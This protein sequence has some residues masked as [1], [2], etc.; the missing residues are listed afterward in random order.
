M[1]CCR[2]PWYRARELQQDTTEEARWRRVPEVLDVIG[3][4]ARRAL[5][6][7]LWFIFSRAEC[8]EAAMRVGAEPR[9]RLLSN[10]EAAL[11]AHELAA[12]R[13]GPALIF[14]PS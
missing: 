11:I 2:L 14:L 13:C 7:A 4:L 9:L 6:P 1:Q 3:E 12:L 10:N 8:D 5:L